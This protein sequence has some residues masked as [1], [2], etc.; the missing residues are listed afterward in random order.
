MHHQL[1]AAGRPHGLELT[2]E[3]CT[4]FYVAVTD[5]GAQTASRVRK[6][7]L[8]SSIHEGKIDGNERCASDGSDSASVNHCFV[9]HVLV[10]RRFCLMQ[11]TAPAPCSA[12]TKIHV[13]TCTF[14]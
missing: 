11:R 3:L 4:T 10:A 8:D 2:G 5:F 1:L 12:A 14:T 13:D 9:V 7:T 6:A